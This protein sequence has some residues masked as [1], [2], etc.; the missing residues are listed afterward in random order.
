MGLAF[1]TARKGPLGRIDVT[2]I[3]TKGIAWHLQPDL[4]KP[5]SALISSPGKMEVGASNPIWA[6][7][8]VNTTLKTKIK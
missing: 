5:A 4:S 2:C 1:L 6:A 8:V 7:S 3:A